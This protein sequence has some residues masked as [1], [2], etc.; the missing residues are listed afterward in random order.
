MSSQD[1][2]QNNDSTCKTNDCD[3]SQKLIDETDLDDDKNKNEKK[4]QDLVKSINYLKKFDWFD[5]NNPQL[6]TPP[7]KL[8]TPAAFWFMVCAEYFPRSLT[9]GTNDPA[10][11]LTE[12]LQKIERQQIFQVI[13]VKDKSYQ[14]L[15]GEPTDEQCQ[16]YIQKIKQ[17]IKKLKYDKPQANIRNSAE[18]KEDYTFED[19]L[20]IQSVRN[21]LLDLY[22]FYINQELQQTNQQSCSSSE[23]T[24][25]E[26]DSRHL[27]ITKDEINVNVSCNEK[28][29]SENAV[30]IVKEIDENNI[31][32]ESQLKQKNEEPSQS[33]DEI[34]E[35]E[36]KCDLEQTNED[37]LN[38]KIEAN[39]SNEEEKLDEEETKITNN[40][41]EIS[42]RKQD[43]QNKL[44]VQRLDIQKPKERNFNQ[45]EILKA[46]KKQDLDEIISLYQYHLFQQ[47]K[48]VKNMVEN[49][50]KNMQKD[51]ENEKLIYTPQELDMN[52]ILVDI[53]YQNSMEQEYLNFLENKQ[54][55]IDFESERQ[56]QNQNQKKQHTKQHEKIVMEDMAC[57]ICNDGDYTDDDLIVF[58]SK[59]NISVHQRC[60][61]IPKIP[62]DDWICELCLSFG[63][64]GKYLRCAL[65]TKRGGAMKPSK[66]P[67]TSNI[68]Q[69][70]NTQYYE[71]QKTCKAGPPNKKQRY[72]DPNEKQN[73]VGSASKHTS[74]E[75]EEVEEESN[76]QY[77]DF[78]YLKEFTEEELKNEP[79][80]Y[81]VWCHITCTLWTP[82][83]FFDDKNYYT[84][85]KGIENIDKQRFKLE[86]S[87]CKQKKAGSCVQCA[88]TKCMEAFH[89]ECA[90]RENIYMEIR[91]TDKLAYLIYCERHTPLKLR[92]LLEQKEK[93]YKEEIIKF[94]RSIE[95]SREFRKKER[96]T[97][98]E[99]DRQLEKEQKKAPAKKKVLIS[100]KKIRQ[101]ITKNEEETNKEEQEFQQMLIHKMIEYID[102][103]TPEDL[104]RINSEFNSKKQNEEGQNIQV[105]QKQIDKDDNKL[106]ANDPKSVK[107]INL[108]KNRVFIRKEEPFWKDIQYKSLSTLQ[109][110]K[111]YKR[112]QRDKNK[113]KEFKQLYLKTVSVVKNI[114]IVT[115]EER[116][117]EKEQKK[118]EK[119]QKR[120]QKIAEIFIKTQ[121]RQKKK[122]EIQERKEQKE[123]QKKQKSQTGFELAKHAI[124]RTNKKRDKSNDKKQ[125]KNL[126]QQELIIE[127][128]VP[129]NYEPVDETSE[130]VYC[131]CRR[132]YQEGDQMMECEKCQEWYHFE[133]IGFKGTIDEADQL[134]FV[135]KFCDLKDD[136]NQRQK[137]RQIY[138]DYFINIDTPNYDDFKD[139]FNKK[140]NQEQQQ[141][142]EEVQLETKEK[143]NDSSRMKSDS[144]SSKKQQKKQTQ[145]KKRSSSTK[146]QDIEEQTTTSKK[147]KKSKDSKTNSSSSKI[148]EVKAKLDYANYSD[149]KEEIFEEDEDDNEQKEEI[150][151]QEDHMHL[152]ELS[153]QDE[154]ENNINNLKSKQLDCNQIEKTLNEQIKFETLQESQCIDKLIENKNQDKCE[155]EQNQKQQIQTKTEHTDTQMFDNQDM[156]DNSALIDK[157]ITKSNDQSH[158]KI[159]KE[160]TETKNDEIKTENQEENESVKQQDIKKEKQE[161]IKNEQNEIINTEEKQEEEDGQTKIN[162]LQEYQYNKKSDSLKIE[163][164]QS[165]NSQNQVNENCLSKQ[166][167]NQNQQNVCNIANLDQFKFKQKSIKDFFKKK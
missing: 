133:C 29:N 7:I 37:N 15:K 30:M 96:N 161:D 99:R 68:F 165:N 163:S 106:N 166:S 59:C 32:E 26:E 160:E 83:C 119:Q 86:C 93:K 117:K 158:M 34:D 1:L 150:Q 108:W 45:E 101:Q 140:Q 157:K 125:Q 105:T 5:T 6:K 88:K 135:C 49:L 81:F 62:N 143:E 56:N 109:I 64:E 27:Y 110:Y 61:G 50:K 126:K 9:I 67:I 54:Q 65:C 79:K 154:Q 164:Q 28:Q 132:K 156:S 23:S 41:E 112:I 102:T 14:N 40:D 4:Y 89:P 127:Q 97:K 72:E 130:Q 2:D 84:N 39:N 155:I 121:E 134:N 141:Q 152:E 116:L 145:N 73:K 53:H 44:L 94:C 100:A 22:S 76:S 42:I 123:V 144:K 147:T 149:A 58:C 137:R 167:S 57:Q 51:I 19:D 70:T 82:E 159:E 98:K 33:Q 48:E 128:V 17:A 13:R 36:K 115:K 11:T 148:S 111:R 78:H 18:L 85:I 8:L 24:T 43:K 118:I 138:K 120:Q 92:R 162:L 142:Q 71:F 10:Q 90:R 87:I 60:Y 103:L 104:N 20:Y 151:H 114:R 95:R 91:N 153:K 3:R 21:D 139:A 75:N 63:P 52:D 25:V 136:E 66:I 124:R 122:L 12:L 38:A 80:P 129:H 55:F 35:K 31:S 69:H 46:L 113:K 74:P 16:E 77:Y 131:V 107:K 47:E 146:L